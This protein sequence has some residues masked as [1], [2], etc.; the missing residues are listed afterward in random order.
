M[1]V[2]VRTM[3]A[4]PGHGQDRHRGRGGGARRDG[5]LRLVGERELDRRIVLRRPERRRCAEPGGLVD[6]REPER[7][8]PGGAEALVLHVGLVQDVARAQETGDRDECGGDEHSIL[9]GLVQ[10]LEQ[11]HT[12]GFTRR[13]GRPHEIRAGHEPGPDRIRCDAPAVVGEVL[14]RKL[15][16]T[17]VVALAV[18]VRRG[19]MDVGGDGGRSLEVLRHQAAVPQGRE[20]GGG[21]RDHDD[22][23]AEAERPVADDERGD[24]GAEEEGE[25]END[26]G[27]DPVRRAQGQARRSSPSPPL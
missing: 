4:G 13:H 16:H 24:A 22:E 17:G 1:G 19:L 9:D 2:S 11:V 5:E 3:C 14:S 21:H 18:H 20:V 6:Q 7:L 23:H 25:P 10:R 27:D 12:A 8:G 26:E 15:Q